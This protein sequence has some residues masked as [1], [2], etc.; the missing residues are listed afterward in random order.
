MFQ[1]L[2]NLL[3]YKAA[4]IGHKIDLNSKPTAAHPGPL[5]LRPALGAA[6][7]QAGYCSL[8]GLHPKD[9]GHASPYRLLVTRGRVPGLL[10]FVF[11][12][13]VFVSTVGCVCATVSFSVSIKFFFSLIRSS[14]WRPP[15]RPWLL[16]D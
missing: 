3:G 6:A 2:E 14:R 5:S 12:G 1:L 16:C 13:R 15:G 10:P 9:G 7:L 8:S 11:S 4:G